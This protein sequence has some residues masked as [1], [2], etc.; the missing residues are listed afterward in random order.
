[1]IDGENFSQNQFKLLPFSE[2]KPIQRIPLTSFVLACSGNNHL[3]GVSYMHI[4]H[5]RLR[6]QEEELAAENNKVTA[7]IY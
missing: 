2:F 4:M 1:M 7:L 5:Q 3:L 6:P